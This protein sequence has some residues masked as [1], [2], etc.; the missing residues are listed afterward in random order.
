MNWQALRQAQKDETAS[1]QG[2]ESGACP[3]AALECRQNSGTCYNGLRRFQFGAAKPLDLVGTLLRFC[4][5]KPVTPG[6]SGSVVFSL[7][8]CWFSI[9]AVKGRGDSLALVMC[10]SLYRLSGRFV[11]RS[12]SVSKLR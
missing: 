6:R 3:P 1:R 4:L 5:N 9:S 11:V 7:L 2:S 12:W 8:S 10:V